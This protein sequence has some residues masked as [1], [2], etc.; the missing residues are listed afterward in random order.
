[1]AIWEYSVVGGIKWGFGNLDDENA[2]TVN[3]IAH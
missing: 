3:G 1:M 2:N